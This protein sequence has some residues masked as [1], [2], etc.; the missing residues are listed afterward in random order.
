M[1]G[2]FVIKTDQ[3][4][5]KYLLEQRIL[6][7]NQQKWVAKLLGYDFEIQ[8]KEGRENRAADALS[9][10]VEVQ[11]LSMVTTE[12]LRDLE[13]ETVADPVLAKIIQDLAI[14]PEVHAGYSLVKGCLWYKGKLV[15]PARSRKIALI[16]QEFH[17]SPWGG[18]SGVLKTYKRVAAVFH[19]KGMKKDIE[20]YVQKCGVCQQNKYQALKPAGLLQPLPIPTQVWEDVTMDFLGGLPKSQRKDTILVVVDRLTKSAHFIPLSHPFSAKEVA[21]VFVDEIIR[22][23]GFPNSI[24]SDRDRIFMSS[25]WRELFKM[26]G[27]KLKFSTAYHPQT[28]GQS[29]VTNRIVEAY[30]RCFVNGY[31]KQWMKWLAWAE[32]WFNSSHNVS[33]GM[34]PFKALY[35]RDPPSIIK[36][37]PEGTVVQ[38]VEQL[39]MERDTILEELKQQLHKAQNNMKLQADKKRRDVSFDEGEMVYLKAQPYKYK[40]LAKRS[41]EKLSP[42]YYGPFQI[43]TRI[44]N[45]A[46]KLQL[47]DHA[48]IHPVFHVSQLKKAIAVTEPSQQLPEFL[49]EEWEL[50]VR[51]QQV[52]AVRKLLNG[53]EQ[54]LVKWD[55]LPDHENTWEDYKSMDAAFPEFHLED[56]VK[57]IGGY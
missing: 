35:G 21:E 18:H 10:V 37:H 1:G 51:P 5:L 7:G 19:W 39:L 9:R 24:V 12:E 14:C 3:R 27:T 2:R 52:L 4:S 42:R 31:P 38:E 54:V 6:D 36:Y 23:H 45:A 56:K 15:I 29:E 57:L 34:S 28:D 17:S 33:I 41:N 40:S 30:L 49:T 13:E 11:A 55:S 46:Y 26:A 53:E 47:P 20:A 32:F 44:G 22:L 16:L 25:F 8:Y 43:Q 48:K 50:Q